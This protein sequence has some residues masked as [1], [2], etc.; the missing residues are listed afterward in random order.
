VRLNADLFLGVVATLEEPR[1]GLRRHRLFVTR[2]VSPQEMASLVGAANT[3]YWYATEVLAK[4][5]GVLVPFDDSIPLQILRLSF[6]TTRAP[7]R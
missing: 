5:R 2:F 7:S 1:L 6:W 4:G 3:P